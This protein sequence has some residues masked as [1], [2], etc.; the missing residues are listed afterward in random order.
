[1]TL[2]AGVKKRN[3]HAAICQ[4]KARAGVEEE[5]ARRIKEEAIPII[6]GVPGLRARAT[7]S[8][9][10]VVE[11]GHAVNSRAAAGTNSRLER[12]QTSDGWRAGP[13]ARRFGR[14]I[15]Q[16]PVQQLHF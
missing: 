9:R 5:L 16:M 14:A 11:L 6:S 3:V 10:E 12:H 2:G 15:L 7:G 8:T 13:G 4:A 1:V